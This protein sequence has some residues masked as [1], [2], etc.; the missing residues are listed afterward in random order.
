[1]AKKVKT[2]NRKS[3]L[4]SQLRRISLKWPPLSNVRKANRR[5]LPRKVKKDGTLFAKPNFEYEC[6]ECKNWFPSG[7]IQV[8]HINPIMGIDSSTLSEKEFY[9]HFVFELFCYEDNLQLLCTSCHDK[10][11]RNEK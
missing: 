7:K 6:N 2:I 1:M 8:D 10:K 11:T 3:W 5:E 9:G 4:T